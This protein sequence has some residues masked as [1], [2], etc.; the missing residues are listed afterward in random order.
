MNR[1]RWLASFIAAPF[2]PLVAQLFPQSSPRR[3]FIGIIRPKYFAVDMEFS[4]K[5]LQW[6]GSPE[7]REWVDGWS[8]RFAEVIDSEASRHARGLS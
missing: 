3:Q 1:R 5:D 7:E 2:L 6:V 4:S 8:R